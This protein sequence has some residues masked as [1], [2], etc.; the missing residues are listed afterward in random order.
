M[1]TKRLLLFLVFA[2]S[3]FAESGKPMLFREPTV[4]RT[5]IVFNYAGDLWI[6]AREGG[7]ATRLT[8]GVGIE[9]DPVFSPDGSQIAF[10]GEYDGNQDVYVVPATG[11]VPRRLTFHPGSDEVRGWMPDGKQV[12]FRSSR[13]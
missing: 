8:A 6:V 12:V 13:N 3:C 1:L 4:S 9:T 11:G 2:S 5:Q 7:N 10:T